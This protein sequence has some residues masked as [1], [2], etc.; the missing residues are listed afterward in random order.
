MFAEI[1][2][3]HDPNGEELVL[4]AEVENELLEQAISEY[5]KIKAEEEEAFA[6][7][8]ED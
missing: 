5:Y 3:I 4:Q 7:M 2:S 1:I 6:C 8:L